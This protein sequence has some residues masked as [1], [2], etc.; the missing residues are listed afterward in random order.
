MLI[1][2]MAILQI[3]AF[4]AI[5]YKSITL[6]G[7]AQTLVI[8]LLMYSNGLNKREDKKVEHD[9]FMQIVTHILQHKESPELDQAMAMRFMTEAPDKAQAIR[10]LQLIRLG[11]FQMTQSKTQAVI[12]SA[13]ASAGGAWASLQDVAYLIDDATM[14]NIKD[15]LNTAYTISATNF[16]TKPAEKELD[17]ALKLQRPSAIL[18]RVAKARQI[19]EEGKLSPIADQSAILETLRKADAIAARNRPTN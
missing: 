14:S 18:R 5:A 16:F 7:I 3:T 13:L 8:L 11:V 10:S 1:F 15:A 17:E 2:A 19:L 12:K 4:A 6:F 9:E